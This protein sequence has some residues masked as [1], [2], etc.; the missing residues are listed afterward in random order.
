MIA[1]ATA[2]YDPYE[3][4]QAVDDHTA[5]IAVGMAIAMGLTGLYFF[6]AVRIGV[7]QKTFACPLVA[8]L[9]FLP[10][11]FSF[12]LHWNDWF[13]V[14]DHWLP[15]VW[16]IGLVG[17]VGLEI[18]L[19]G[20][21]IRYGRDELM[22]AFSQRA[23]AAVIVAAT[24]GVAAV[25][26]FVRTALDDDLFYISFFLT[27]VWPVLFTTPQILRRGSRRGTSVLQQACLAPMM[28]GLYLALWNMDDFFREPAFAVMVALVSVWS[29]FNIW[30]YLQ[31][32]EEPAG[33]R[34][35]ADLVGAGA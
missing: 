14:Y 26:F 17:T 15:Q 22:P 32:P 19:L 24:V 4:L 23:F 25:W 16:C 27:I 35:S 13:Q 33:R 11:D 21:V 34:D 10:H 20:Q 29:F 1:L 6:E 12:V 8:T 2:T 7:R 9:W 18:F 31:Q 30:L 28:W 5:I 3:V